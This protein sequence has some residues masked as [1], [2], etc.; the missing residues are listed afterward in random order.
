VSLKSYLSLVKFSHSVFALPFALMGAWLAADGVPS[1]RAL[2]LIVVAAVAARTA[3]MGFNRLVDRHIDAK[4]PRT[5]GRELPTG[6][7]STQGAGVLVLLASGVFVLASFS[8]NT[9]CGWMSPFVLALLLGYSFAK[10]FTS[11]VHFWLGL[12][13]G[14]APPAAWLAVRGSFAGDLSAPLLLGAAV[15]T[16]VAGFDVIYSCQDAAFDAGRE[17]HSLPARLGVPRALGLARVLHGATVVLLGLVAWR[18]DLSWI[19]LVAL[20]LAGLLLVWEH[21]IVSP[22]DLSRVDMAFF[23]LNGWVGVGL[24]LGTAADLWLLSGGLS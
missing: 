2:L 4:N 13:L 24:F 10:R 19:F 23:T 21:S 8:L 7:I 5:A 11:L 16:W 17:L 22:D 1:A 6:R 3:A 20:V 18:A 15:L 14:V 12:A 9:L